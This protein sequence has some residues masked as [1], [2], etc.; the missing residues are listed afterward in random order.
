MRGTTA[1]GL[2]VQTD[3]VGFSFYKAKGPVPS[4]SSHLSIGLPQHG[5][6]G[7]LTPPQKS[8]QGTNNFEQQMSSCV[9]ATTTK[10]GTNHE[11]VAPSG[12]GNGS[13]G[14][15]LHWVSWLRQQGFHES[16]VSVGDRV[17]SCL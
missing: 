11:A 6:E 16:E 14:P 5:Y 17:K 4:T 8:T 7:A 3:T 10:K 9:V 12:C 15:S 13:G 2:A 1:G